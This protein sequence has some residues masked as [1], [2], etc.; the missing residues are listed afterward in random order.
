MSSTDG[1]PVPQRLVDRV[2]EGPAPAV[3][4]SHLGTEQLHAEH[5]ELL[6]VGVHL[7]HVDDA[8]HAEEGRGGGRGHTVLAG[9]GLGDQAVLAHPPGQQSLADHVVDLVRT[10]VGQVL[11]LE[12]HPHARARAD[13]RPHSVTGVGRPP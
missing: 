4:R 2:L 8:L 11:A 5:V 12:Q 3:H 10:G 6:A 1:H 7:A 13:R 9:A